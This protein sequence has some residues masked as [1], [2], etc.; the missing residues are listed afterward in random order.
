MT[1]GKINRI[2]SIINLPSAMQ[3]GERLTQ[4]TPFVQC[5]S[6]CQRQIHKIDISTKVLGKDFVVK[7][8]LDLAGANI[9]P[10]VPDAISEHSTF[11]RTLLCTALTL[12]ESAK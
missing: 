4:T 8:S 10:S 2:R 7:V 11:N 9:K 12:M 1:L 3:S 5:Y 6:I